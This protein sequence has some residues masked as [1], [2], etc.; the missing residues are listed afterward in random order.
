MTGTSPKT[1]VFF[2]MDGRQYEP[3]AILLA[4]SLIHH[5]GDAFKIIAYTPKEKIPQITPLTTKVLKGWGVQIRPLPEPDVDGEIWA[6]P[7]PHGNKILAALDERD[8]D[9]S[10]FF[11]TDMIC[12]GAL[13]LGHMISPN[14]MGAMVSDYKTWGGKKRWE[15]AYKLFDLEVPELRV[16]FH[17]GQRLWSPPYFNAG[18]VGFPEKRG[19]DGM[20]FSQIWFETARKLDF[21]SGLDGLR[22]NLD[23]IALPIATVRSNCDFEIFSRDYN[24][25]IQNADYD[26]AISPKIMHYHKPKYLANW[27]QAQACF[28][29][30]RKAVGEKRYRRLCSRF[31]GFFKYDL[32]APKPIEE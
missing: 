22:W 18:L 8:C 4:A 26:P 23:Q 2:M 32:D 15:R 24:F 13:D 21:E 5:N 12:T 6:S 11:D 31:S 9:L 20:T 1:S 25:N 14:H 27:P 10:Y 28:A 7:Y 16:Q 19:A 29:S 30:C 17:R 3:M